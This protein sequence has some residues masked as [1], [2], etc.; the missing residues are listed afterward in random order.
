M[1]LL[2]WLQV[3]Q[4]PCSDWVS[5]E[6]RKELGVVAVAVIV[7]AVAAAA[8]VAVVQALDFEE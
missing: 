7:I 2:P 4:Y 6:V 8:V 1:Y 3:D 5:K